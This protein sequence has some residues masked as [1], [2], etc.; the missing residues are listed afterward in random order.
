[1][2]IAALKRD[3]DGIKL[4]DNPAIVQQKS[5]DFY[6]YSPVL[7]QQLDHVTGDLVVTPKN[8]AELIRVLAACHRHG[9]PVTPRGSGTG[10]YGQAMPLSGGVVLNLAEM[11]EIK[12]IAPGRVVTGPG[13]VL[14]DIDKA[15]RAHSGQE[16][17]LSPS[18][19]NTASIGGFIAGGSGG[20]GSI[21]FG[22]LRDFGNVLRLR[23]VTMEAEPRALELT[24]EDL[25]K[26]THAYGTNGII[27]EVEMPLTAAYE[28]IDIIVG[29]D[30]F[31]NAARYGNAL[32]C[33]D[34]ILTKLITPIAAPVPQLY[35]KRHQKFLKDG[36]SICVVMVARHGLDAFLAFTRRAGGE[37]VFNAATATPEEKKGLPPAYELAWNHTTLRALRIDPDI[38]YLQSLYPFPN[39]LA[40]VEKM[41]A[42]FPGEVFS[43]LEFVRLDGNITC[44]GLP[45]VKFTTEARLDEIIRLHE[46]NGCPIFNPHR[47]TL[48]EGGMK[49]TDAVQLAFK[50]ETD[51]QGL[52]NPGK[53]IAWENPDYDYRSGRTFLFKGLQRT[54]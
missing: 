4:D 44:F 37:V 1:M 29:F 27:T 3:L 12:S 34:G 35:F 47:Y 53:M 16:L 15:T 10:N 38:T 20:V 30:A 7:K 50:R 21:N 48:E 52:L 8:E 40:L 31:M 2:D 46:E 9:V 33:Q 14:A 28:W 18:T 23:V 32:A 6:W 17:R 24:G 13:A 11:N 49:Q 45:L 51:P 19:Y 43:H 41:D 54:G 25:H 5:R 36:Q 42:M 39:Q 26:V 22:G